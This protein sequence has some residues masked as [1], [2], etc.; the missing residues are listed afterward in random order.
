MPKTSK[1][2]NVLQCKISLRHIK[3]AIW[4]RV[5]VPDNIFLSE[6]HEIIQTAMGWD[7]Y[8]LHAFSINGI[9]YS[10]SET[11]DMDEMNVENE[12]TVRLSQVITG[13]KQKIYYEYDFG[14]R[15]EHV[16]VVEKILPFDP[17]AKYP[18]CLAG[19]RAC[20]PEDCGS[21]PGYYDIL[22]A[23]Q[24]KEDEELLEWL[25]EYD[26]EHFDLETVNARLA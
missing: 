21:E 23:L 5:L 25:G 18:I 11:S 10:D 19:K 20:P 2:Q 16:I 8:H 3:P 17:T 6:F 14:D 1:T 4:R 15:W 9:Q 12:E 26:P 24:N 22:E 13:P 7:N